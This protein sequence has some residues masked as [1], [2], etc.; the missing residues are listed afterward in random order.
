[1]WWLENC[2]SF[3][4]RCAGRRSFSSWLTGWLVVTCW[5]SWLPSLLWATVHWYYL[6]WCSY[7]PTLVHFCH[8]SSFFQALPYCQAYQHVSG[9]F[10]T[11]SRQPWFLSVWKWYLESMIWELG[12]IIAF[13]VSLC[14]GLSADRA[15]ERCMVFTV[16][17]NTDVSLQSDATGFLLSSLIHRFSFSP[18]PQRQYVY[19]FV[20]FCKHTK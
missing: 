15:G 2:D 3:C 6:F 18:G 17:F 9:I 11:F 4:W 10:S 7:Y 19:S 5:D 12:V 16:A 14:L 20:E 1:M 13:W 8:V